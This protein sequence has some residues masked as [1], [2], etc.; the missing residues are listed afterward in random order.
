[1][2]YTYALRIALHPAVT[3][4]MLV[5]VCAL[6]LTHFVSF[7]NVVANMLNRKLG[8][9]HLFFFESAQSTE[10]WTILL[11]GVLLLTAVSFYIQMSGHR[12]R[13]ENSVAYSR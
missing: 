5:L 4:G 10:G 9:V 13:P 11:F 12:S 2:Y 6:L 3:H 8:E 1:M 7:P